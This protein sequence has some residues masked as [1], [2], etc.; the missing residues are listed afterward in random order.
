MQIFLKGPQKKGLSYLDGVAQ[1]ILGKLPARMLDAP[2]KE[3]GVPL[4]HSYVWGPAWFSLPNRS[5]P[6]AR[7]S[8]TAFNMDGICLE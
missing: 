2:K 4:E 8:P 7:G 6:G 3:N 5:L 1:L